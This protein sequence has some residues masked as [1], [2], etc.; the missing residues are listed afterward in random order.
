MCAVTH[1]H[2]THTHIHKHTHAIQVF[3]YIYR[4]PPLT[5]P[6]LSYVSDVIADAFV[7]VVVCY[8]VTLSLEK[9]FAK[10][11]GYTIYPNQVSTHT[12]T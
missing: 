5:T 8:S 4:P 9:V 2:N 6:K 11:H 3:L 7:A 10:K 1:T 12:H